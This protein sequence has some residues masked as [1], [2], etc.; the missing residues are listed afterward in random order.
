MIAYFRVLDDGIFIA[1]DACSEA[2]DRLASLARSHNFLIWHAL[3]KF[4]AVQGSAQSVIR[5]A[6]FRDI[7]INKWN[8]AHRRAVAARDVAVETSDI[9]RACAQCHGPA[10]GVPDARNTSSRLGWR[11]TPLEELSVASAEEV[12]GRCPLTRGNEDQ[13]AVTL[14][15]RDL[16]DVGFKVVTKHRLLDSSSSRYSDGEKW[17]VDVLR[18][19]G[20]NADESSV[21]DLTAAMPRLMERRFGTSWGKQMN[22][23]SLELSDDLYQINRVKGRVKA[24]KGAKTRSDNEDFRSRECALCVYGCEKPPYGHKDIRSCHATEASVLSG[25]VSVDASWLHR[26][27]ISGSASDNFKLGA[28]GRKKKGIVYG[29]GSGGGVEIVSRVSPYRSLGEISVRDLGLV[30]GVEFGSPED[31]LAD[32]RAR[33]PDLK[34]ELVSWALSQ[35]VSYAGRGRGIRWYGDGRG[36]RNDVLSIRLLDRGE[37]RVST[38]TSRGDGLSSPRFRFFLSYPYFESFKTQLLKFPGSGRRNAW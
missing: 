32:Y 3:D 31:W 34:M 27:S 33:N 30:L 29:P 8:F 13:V 21:E 5:N 28:D 6:P 16:G 18:D 12:W 10:E 36:K 15:A 35:M 26:F 37:I 11:S 9:C 1:V 4:I 23:S 24:V 19:K 2:F 38:D 25:A 14:R 22:L 7:D 17:I 20:L